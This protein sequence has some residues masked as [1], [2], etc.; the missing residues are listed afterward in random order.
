MATDQGQAG[1]GGQTAPGGEGMQ[2]ERV[3]DRD[4]ADVY[5]NFF[6]LQASNE[7]LTVELG[8]YPY[9]ARNRYKA[10]ARLHMT[11]Y[12][13]KRL[14]L[15]LMNAVRRYEE[16]FGTLELDARNREVTTETSA[17][18]TAEGGPTQ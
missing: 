2:L 17:G 8:T 7:D 1:Q 6:S 4:L 11:L 14:S 9:L 18:G 13:A 3:E 10:M 16:R 12:N 5:A 15:A